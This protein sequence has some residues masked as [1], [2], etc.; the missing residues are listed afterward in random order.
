M[1]D[2]TTQKI[3]N[4]VNAKL[5]LIDSINRTQLSIAI[6]TWP[7]RLSFILLPM[8]GGFFYSQKNSVA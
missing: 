7:E 8:M 1:F 4:E 6:P 5:V 3:V 2:S